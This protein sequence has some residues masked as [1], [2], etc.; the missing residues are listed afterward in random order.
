[1]DKKKWNKEEEH[2]SIGKQ[3][4]LRTFSKHEQMAMQL[5]KQE[6]KEIRYL[7]FLNKGRGSRLK[8]AKE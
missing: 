8:N 2:M 7:Y 5:S 6:Y 1:M 4:A 3:N